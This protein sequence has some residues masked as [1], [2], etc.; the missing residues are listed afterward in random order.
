MSA[1]LYRQIAQALRRKIE[2]DELAEGARVP[3]ENQLMETYQA[4]RNTV[5]RA[6]KDLAN[7]GL[8]QALPGRGIFVSGRVSPVV[9]TLTSDP[10]TGAGGGEGLHYAA[11]V[12]ASGR[13]SST[14]G[15]RVEIM[16]APPAVAELLRIP[17]D[18]EVISRR[19]RG[20]VDGQPWS[21]QASYY[22]RALADRAPRLLTTDDIADGTVAYLAE[23]GIS[24]AGYQDLIGWRAPDEE[25]AHYFDLPADGHV[26][27]VEINRLAFDQGKERVRLTVTVYRADRNRFIINVGDVIAYESF[28]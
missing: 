15:I 27:V 16:K 18:T 14:R 9:T 22:P 21:L 7:H 24:Q 10:A 6:L 1:P 13:S 12:A 28:H 5:R 2:S 17:E 19:Q 25:E 4:S 26:Q 8:V 20:Y 23:R 3:T 11:E